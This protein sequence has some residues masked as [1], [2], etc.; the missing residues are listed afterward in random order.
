MEA[1]ACSG[2]VKRVC[3]WPDFWYMHRAAERLKML[4][5]E[6]SSFSKPPPPSR[7]HLHDPEAYCQSQGCITLNRKSAGYEKIDQRRQTKTPTGANAEP[8]PQNGRNKGRAM[9]FCDKAFTMS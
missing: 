9:L 3:T 2:L 8:C 1:A 6:V 4:G 7:L 5:H